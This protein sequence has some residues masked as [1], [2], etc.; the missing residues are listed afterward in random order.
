[1][2]QGNSVE[3][4]AAKIQEICREFIREHYNIARVQSVVS[5]PWWWVGMN[6]GR[7]ARLPSGTPASFSR[8]SIPVSVA[9]P[10]LERCDT[11]NTILPLHEVRDCGVNR[12]R[13][14]SHCR[15]C[16]TRFHSAITLLD[17][18]QH[19]SL[20]L[21]PSAMLIQGLLVDSRSEYSHLR[22]SRA[23]V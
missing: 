11:L 2:R 10:R 15:M 21:P 13:Y 16:S 7:L 12:Q 8:T 23:Q 1:M 19:G 5:H 3:H 22:I 20:A 14:L 18:R 17:G 9:V 6:S 4:K